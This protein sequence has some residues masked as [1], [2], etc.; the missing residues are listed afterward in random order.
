[1]QAADEDEKAL[2]DL[3]KRV[4]AMPPKRREES[5]IGKPT[6]KTKPKATP[7]EKR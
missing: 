4:L 3:A 2:S 1:M 5:K 7:T 6:A